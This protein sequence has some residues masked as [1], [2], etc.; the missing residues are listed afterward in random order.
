MRLLTA[1]VLQTAALASFLIWAFT[2]MFAPM[3]FAGGD[4]TN[5]RVVFGL[6]VAMPILM[7]FASVAIWIGYAR[8][9]MQ[10]MTVATVFII[11]SFLPLLWS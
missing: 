11:L 8:N 7:I 1:I 4:G 10:T 6:F 5:T 3:L 9:Q 2:A